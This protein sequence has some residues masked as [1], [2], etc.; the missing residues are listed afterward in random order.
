MII[1]NIAESSTKL[2]KPKRIL[3]RNHGII[4]D[5]FQCGPKSGTVSKKW[6]TFENF[7]SE[8]KCFDMVV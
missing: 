2:R 6:N 8:C 3:R 4:I 5:Q 1:A 7:Q